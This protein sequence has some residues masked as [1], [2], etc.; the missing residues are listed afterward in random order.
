MA[1]SGSTDF[2]LFAADVVKRAMVKC[3]RCAVDSDPEPEEAEF[4]LGT[5]MA[6]VLE[7]QDQKVLLWTRERT[8]LALTPTGGDGTGIIYSLANDT[9]D[10]IPEEIQ[11]LPSGQTT[12]MPVRMIAPKDYFRKPDRATS[13]GIP[14]QVMVEKNRAVSGTPHAFT[15][16]LSL[17]VYPIPDGTYTLSYTRVRRLADLD[18]GSNDIDAPERWTKVLV[19]LLAAEISPDCGLN[20]TERADLMQR[21]T[22]SR[23]TA[24]RNDRD[25]AP[26]KF[27]PRS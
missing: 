16:R 13:T 18:S 7:L 21:A 27:Y 10:I 2:S 11:V 19:D 26:T 12:Y 4:F 5:L 14:I 15:G 3:N 1:L 20:A 25:R 9:L 8:T 17:Y 23:T 24:L 22:F 6:L